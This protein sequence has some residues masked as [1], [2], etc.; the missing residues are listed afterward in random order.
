M[1]TGAIPP[2]AKPVRRRR[3]HARADELR[4]AALA[5]FVEKGFDATRIEEIAVRAGISKGTLYLYYP[6]KETLLRAAIVSPALVAFSKVRPAAERGGSRADVLR[7]MLSD[8]WIHL[9]DQTVSSVL[10]LAIAEARRFPEIMEVWL[11]GVVRPVRTLIVEVVV[12]GMNRGE[13]RKMDADLVAHSLLQ[14]MFM[15]CLQRSVMDTGTLA[16]RCPD[17]NFIPLHVEL[18]L[19]GL[20]RHS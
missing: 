14:P 6:S 15:L 12:Q 13:F 3:K 16:D 17:E 4:D 10:K 20:C 11:R 8:I 9:Q 2:D 18:V 1:T 19:Q 5:L 7:H